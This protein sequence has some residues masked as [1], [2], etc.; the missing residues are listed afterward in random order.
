M[1]TAEESKDA[2]G[3][4]VELQGYV[5]PSLSACMV[6]TYVRSCTSLRLYSFDAEGGG[7]YRDSVIR[8]RARTSERM[9]LEWKD[10]FY[11][12]VVGKKEM[13]KETVILNHVSGFAHSGTLVA[14][15]GPTGS[16]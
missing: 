12:V 11:S 2:N 3:A 9:S 16:G 1:M 6:Y 5:C 8:R 13:R 15:L 14:I 10:L 4:A 7:E